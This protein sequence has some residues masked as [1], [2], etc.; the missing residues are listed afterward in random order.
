M[1]DIVEKQTGFTFL[2][3]AEKI[4]LTTPISI[5]T[6]EMPLKEFLSAIFKDQRISFEV[7]EKTIVLLTKKPTIIIEETPP[8]TIR[9]RIVNEK[10]EPVAASIVIKGANKGATT[11]SYGNFEMAN[12]EEN[13]IIVISAVGLQSQEI[14]A[15]NISQTIVLKISDS[16]L[17]E[18]VFKGYYSESKRLSTGSVSKV[19]AADIEKQPVSNP[20]QAITG[21]MPVAYMLQKGLVYPEE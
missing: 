10:G 9:G 13:A 20:L 12:V 11:D 7:R 16:K 8:I 14:K 3:N 17:D 1:M 5:A 6:K 21:R 15:A 19:T 2:F 4:N 18:I